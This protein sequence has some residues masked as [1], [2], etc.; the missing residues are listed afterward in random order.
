M[1]IEGHLAARVML[2][3]LW[4]SIAKSLY[5]VLVTLSLSSV[6]ISL[7]NERRVLGH[8]ISLDQ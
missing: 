6:V 2:L 8:V 3:R 5:W 7:T 4:R 1:T